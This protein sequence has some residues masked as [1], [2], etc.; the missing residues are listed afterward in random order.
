MKSGT[1]KHLDPDGQWNGMKKT[2]VTFKDG[3]AYTFFSKGEFTGSIGDTI[4]YNVT[5]EDMYNAKLIRQ[6]LTEAEWQHLKNKKFK[7][8]EVITEKKKSTNTFSYI[9]KKNCIKASANFHSKR[10]ADI[11]DVLR[12]AE[13]M[14]NWII[15]K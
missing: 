10:V 9:V 6:N 15:N 7:D 1:I 14:Y 8:N 13:K 4:K 12:D 5:N 2:K 3:R 11:D